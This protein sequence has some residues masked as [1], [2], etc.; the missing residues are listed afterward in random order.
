MNSRFTETIGELNEMYNIFD[1]PYV[2]PTGITKDVLE[3]TFIDYYAYREIA[4]ETYQRW[5]LKFKVQWMNAIEKYGRMFN[6][7]WEVFRTYLNT[8]VGSSQSQSENES[9][10]KNMPTPTTNTVGVD[11]VPASYN[12]G[13]GKSSGEVEA[14]STTTRQSKSDVEML[15]EYQNNYNS[16]LMLFIKSFNNL[17]LRRY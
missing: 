15:V 14:T 12:S 4:Y 16:I 2:V 17:M 1:F 6:H 13:S 7:E 11:E 8:N 3:K 5:Y 10:N 9:V